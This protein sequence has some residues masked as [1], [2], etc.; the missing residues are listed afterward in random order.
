MF[1]RSQTT[2]F[3]KQRDLIDID[4]DINY[5]GYISYPLLKWVDIVF[6]ISVYRYVSR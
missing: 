4:V 3:K 6:L 1:H 5:L 2:T